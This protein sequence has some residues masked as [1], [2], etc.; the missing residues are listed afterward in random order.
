MDAAE[1]DQDIRLQKLAADL[2]ADL[3]R[4]L[5]GYLRKADG[6]GGTRL[7]SR[8][9]I[10]ETHRLVGSVRPSHFRYLPA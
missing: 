1:E 4:S 3:D 10:W 5:P 8:V 9:R 7:R 2:I 6:A